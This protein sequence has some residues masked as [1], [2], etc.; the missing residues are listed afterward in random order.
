MR[1]TIR[2]K[3]AFR[4]TVTFIATLCIVALAACSGSSDDSDGKTT[5]KFSYLWT[6]TEGKAMK[7]IIDDFNAT[8]KKVHVKGTSNPDTKA[9]VAA[10]TS[11]KSDFD[12]SDTWGYNT[13]SWAAKGSLEPLN[14]RIK[15]D[16]YSLSDYVP[17]SLQPCKYK[18]KLYCLPI[19]VHTFMLMY[20][21]T[22]FRKAGISK[23]P[24]TMSELAS[25]SQKLTKSK[26]GKLTQLGFGS[27]EG[28]SLKPDDYLLLAMANGGQWYTHGKPTPDNP[29]NISAAS[30]YKDHILDKYGAS[31]VKRFTGGF[32]EYQSAQNPFYTGKLAMGID[33]EYQSALAKHYNPKLKWGVAPI[34]YPDGHP[35]LANTSRLTSSTLFIPRNSEHKTQ[36]WQFLKYLESKPVMKKFT[37]ALTNLPARKSLTSSSAYDKFPHFH[38]WLQELKSRNLNTIPARPS[39]SEYDNDLEQAFDSINQGKKTPRSALSNVA[40]KTSNYN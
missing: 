26:N 36:A 24:K 7:K 12:I 23:P 30:F 15:R 5:I 31:E 2:R 10:M 32:G 9:Q 6:G 13:G 3:H 28:E 11:S 34:P 17:E 20:N 25:D 22:L 29:K 18:G 27:T 21:K 8:H 40:T 16:N 39:Y 14:S 35:E 38:A 19:G 4:V 1:P 33:G 37:Q